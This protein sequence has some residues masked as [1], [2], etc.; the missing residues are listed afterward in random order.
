M[1]RTAAVAAVLFVFGTACSK[2]GPA[3]QDSP[4]ATCQKANDIQRK[5]T[6]AEAAIAAGAANAGSLIEDLGGAVTNARDAAKEGTAVAVD[7]EVVF[8]DVDRLDNDYK[9]DKGK[10]AGDVNSLKDSLIKLGM[11]CSDVL[12]G[13]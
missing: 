7:L 13:G 1:R 3:S 6:A 9:N 2:G 5:A 11:D 8:N 4:K 12:T 10:V